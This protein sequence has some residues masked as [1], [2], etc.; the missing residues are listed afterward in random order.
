M[1][2]VTRHIGKLEIIRRLPC[3]INGNPRFVLRVDGWTCRTAVDSS[4]GYEVQNHDGKFVVA[5][6]GTHY[7]VATLD[8]VKRASMDNKSTA[9]DI[10]LRA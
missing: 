2:N 5:T 8:S 9:N 3:S 1:K 6:V 4:L 7:G 10:R